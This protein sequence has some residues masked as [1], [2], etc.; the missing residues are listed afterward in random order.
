MWGSGRLPYNEHCY[1]RL[2]NITKS[3]G[4]VICGFLW[5]E[6]CLFTSGYPALFRCTCTLCA[7]ESKNKTILEK[8]RRLCSFYTRIRTEFKTLLWWAA[9]A[10][11]CLCEGHNCSDLCW[12]LDVSL[13]PLKGPFLTVHVSFWSPYPA[14][15]WAPCGGHRDLNHVH[16][17]PKPPLPLVEPNNYIQELKEPC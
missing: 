2:R 8:Q 12:G 14:H 13:I 16:L 4:N 6:S 10:A 9:D 7:H 1:T 3:L 15:T 11:L 5:A 17:H